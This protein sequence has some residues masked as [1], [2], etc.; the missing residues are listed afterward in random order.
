MLPVCQDL[1]AAAAG[2]S[3]LIV[4]EFDSGAPLGAALSL[5]TTGGGRLGF[6]VNLT[7]ARAVGLDFNARLLQLARRVY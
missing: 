2:Q 4:T 7:A 3:L 1:L 6:D 5:V